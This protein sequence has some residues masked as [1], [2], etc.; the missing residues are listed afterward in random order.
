M[1]AFAMLGIG[2]VGWIEK[3]KPV[4]GPYDAIVKPIA[5]APCTSDI[6]TIEGAIGDRKNLVLGHESVGEVVE[7]GS[8]VKYIKPGDRVVVPAIT[9]DWRSVELQDTGLGQHS[10]GMLAGWKFSNIK[11][12]VFSEYFHVNDGD[13][14]LAVLP[15][16]ITLEAAVM[17]TD[18]VT[19]GFHGV[20]LANVEYGDTVVVLGIGPVGLM[21]VAGAQLMGAGR[22]VGVGSRPALIEAA[23]FYGATDIVNYRERSVVDR[24]L[25]MTNNRGADK[26]IVAGGNCDILIDAVK[27]LKAGG[28]IGNINY[29][30]GDEFIPIPREAWGVGMGHKAINGG[31]TPGGRVRMERLIEL[32]KYSRLD[33]GKLVTHVFYGFDK[34]E[35]A[36]QLMKEKPADLIKPV[37]L[38]D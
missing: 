4:A 26:V 31:L 5:F 17:L 14:N 29:F 24:V 10:G 20:E 22:I 21:S 7:V 25:E 16:G 11:D 38:I 9:P 3:E 18:M 37:V 15:D 30:G 23:K 28:A 2:S 33:P 34:I 32:V 1:K 6:H 36:L 19:T 13:M 8:E 12:G 27:I 35:E